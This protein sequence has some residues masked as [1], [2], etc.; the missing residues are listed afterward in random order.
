MKNNT[1]EA[2]IEQISKHINQNMQT[3]LTKVLEVLD[4]QI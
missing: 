3:N 4:L 1:K 2:N